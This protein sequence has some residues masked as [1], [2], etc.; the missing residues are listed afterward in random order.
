MRLDSKVI[1]Y[2]S[3]NNTDCRFT[4]N[5][6]HSLLSFHWAL[7]FESSNYHLDTKLEQ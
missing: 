4:D 2:Y 7:N 6:C 5:I 3:M 1:E